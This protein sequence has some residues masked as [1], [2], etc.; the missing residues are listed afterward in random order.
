MHLDKLLVIRKRRLSPVMTDSKHDL[1]VSINAARRFTP[2]AINQLWW[3]TL[4]MC[5]WKE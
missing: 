2:T 5:G 4:S 1:D 3:V